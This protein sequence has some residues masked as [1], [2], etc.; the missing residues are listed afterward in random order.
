M[1]RRCAFWM[2][3][4]LALLT[5]VSAWAAEDVFHAVPS[6]ALAF[7]A[8]NRIAETSAKVRKVAGQV[9]APA[10]GLL[11]LAK[12][13][14]GANKGLDETRAAAFVVMPGKEAK[15]EP[16]LVFLIPVSDY[17]QFLEAWDAKPSEKEKVVEVT[18]AGEPMLVAQ[19]GDYAAMAPKKSPMPNSDFRPGLEKLVASKRSVADEYPQMLT[20]LNEN[21]A[22][23]VGTSHG[24]KLASDAI[25]E[26]L[27]RMKEMFGDMGQ[28]EGMVSPVMALEMYAKL[29]QWAGKEVDTL[30]VAAR[31][32]QQGTLHLSKRVLFG[33]D[34]QFGASLG[35]LQAVEKG[36]LAGLPPGAFLLA[37]GG[38]WSDSAGKGMVSFQSDLMK[39]SFRMT[40]GLDEKQAEELAKRILETP[41]GIRAFSVMMGTGQPGQ[42][43]L[44]DM[45]ALY[46][47]ENAEKYLAEYL[48]YLDDLNKAVKKSDSADAKELFKA[49]KTEIEGRPA[50]ESETPIPLPQQVK[51]VP[52]MEDRMGKIFGSGGKLKTVLV[53]VDEHTIAL[54]FTDRAPFITRA[55][56]A[57]KKPSEGLASDAEIAKTAAMLPTGAQWVG[58]FNPSGAVAFA[59]GMVD[60][61]SEEGGFK[62]NI[63][64]FP[65]SP[66]IGIA[67]K[68]LPGELQTE[69]VVPSAVLDAIGKYVGTIKSTEHPEVP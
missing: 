4:A 36:P 40:Y 39:Q 38:P 32:D 65:A 8:A 43:V 50:V 52:G 1:V 56:A 28:Q 20:W 25:Q 23:A 33:K 55:I 37:A 61:M 30:A 47:V 7:V 18:I 42:P 53:A 62:P 2:A 41:K 60:A 58:Y 59:K 11:E 57:A 68:T 49:K 12:A 3:A 27:K 19:H 21:D 34:S 9:G 67:V 66:P 31:I 46:H 6:E 69:T 29:F 44:A 45:L 63:P 35:K 17:K 26:Q 16:S 54:S 48:K 15:G 22:V 14:S 64:E 5:V 51:E 24:V 13:F 10:V